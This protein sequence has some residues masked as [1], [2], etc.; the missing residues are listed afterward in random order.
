MPKQKTKRAAK[1]RFTLSSKGKLKRRP[2]HQAHFNARATGNDTRRKHG[3]EVVD[4]SD[5][6]RIHDILPYIK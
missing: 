2:V 4:A 3:L 5:A 1:K 6:P